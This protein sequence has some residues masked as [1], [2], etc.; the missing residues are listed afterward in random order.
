[1]KA[2]DF[3]DECGATVRECR[4]YADRVILERTVS[5]WLKAF[6]CLAVVLALLRVFKVI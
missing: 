4:E 1:M 6:F 5:A 2:D 3:T